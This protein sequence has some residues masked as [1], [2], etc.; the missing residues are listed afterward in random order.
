MS[1]VFFPVAAK[2]V[3]GYVCIVEV[4]ERQIELGLL[5]KC[6]VLIDDV[7]KTFQSLAVISCVIIGNRDEPNH[8]IG[9][10]GCLS[11]RVG[12]IRDRLR[13]DQVLDFQ[14]VNPSQ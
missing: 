11:E 7:L 1:F 14:S 8:I 2:G 12:A 9:F 4:L 6:H 10:A 3:L 5:Q 13:L